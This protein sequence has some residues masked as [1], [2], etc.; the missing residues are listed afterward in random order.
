MW[1]LRMDRSTTTVCAERLPF[2]EFSGG[3]SAL[4]MGM[5]LPV[6]ATSEGLWVLRMGRTNSVREASGGLLAFRIGRPNS[7]SIEHRRMRKEMFSLRGF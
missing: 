3:L 2:D 1:L 7:L 4:H 5:T 6:P